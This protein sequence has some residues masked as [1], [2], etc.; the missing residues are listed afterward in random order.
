M[1]PLGQADKPSGGVE[2]TCL[3]VNHDS[4]GTSPPVIVAKMRNLKK[5]RNV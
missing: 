1:P 2:N 3:A 5:M 4:T